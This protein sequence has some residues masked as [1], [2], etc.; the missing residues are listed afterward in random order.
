MEQSKIK[1][2]YAIVINGSKYIV[3]SDNGIISLV[4]TNPIINTNTVQ[5]EVSNYISQR[6]QGDNIWEIRKDLSN[7]QTI[8]NTSNE[9]TVM[10]FL[11]SY[12]DNKN[13]EN[14]KL[15]VLNSELKNLREQIV[16]S[17]NSDSSQSLDDTREFDI[18]NSSY[19]N[20]KQ[21]VLTNGKSLLPNDKNAYVNALIL[22]FIVEVVGIILSIFVLLKIQV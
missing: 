2:I 17:F 1:N 5:Y 21:M 20:G 14:N 18:N 12:F 9:Q 8:I 11:K 19:Q 22:A 15:D 6:I 4:N 7:I 10:G 3:Q 16:E 13:Q